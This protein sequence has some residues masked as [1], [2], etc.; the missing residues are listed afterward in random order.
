L[1]RWKNC[2]IGRNGKKIR[3]YYPKL[4]NGRKPY[5]LSVMLRLYCMQLFY[6]LSDPA[7]EEAMYE[8]KSMRRFAGLSLTD[9]MQEEA[10]ILIF[11]HLLERYRLGHKL[12]KEINEYLDESGLILKKGTIIDASIIAV[13]ASTKKKAGQRDPQ[14]HQTKGRQ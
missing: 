3:R 8:I 4:G 9:L 12:F 11:C 10:T 5:W 14:V 6:N 13:P 7:I 1:S 2:C